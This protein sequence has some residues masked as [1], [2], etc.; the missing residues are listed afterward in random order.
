MEG[1]RRKLAAIFLLVIPEQLEKFEPQ[2][3][4][5]NESQKQAPFTFPFQTWVVEL[6]VIIFEGGG[7]VRKSWLFLLRPFYKLR[8]W[9]PIQCV[10]A[11]HS[12]HYNDCQN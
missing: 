5:I 7:A 10:F 6:V 12:R 2:F 4:S 8:R 11:G 1:G 3:E 9:P